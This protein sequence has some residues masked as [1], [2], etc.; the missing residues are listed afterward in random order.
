MYCR[1]FGFKCAPFPQN[2]CWLSAA[3]ARQPQNPTFKWK[4]YTSVYLRVSSNN[5]NQIT[6]PGKPLARKLKKFS[7]VT[8]TSFIKFSR[9]IIS[10]VCSRRPRAYRAAVHHVNHGVLFFFSFFFIPL[11]F[12]LHGYATERR[13]LGA[14]LF[15][16]DQIQLHA[17]RINILNYKYL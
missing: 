6:S 4:Y 17:H 7:P 3:H 5:N 15:C 9:T 14:K 10:R 12:T 2:G 1:A 16:N 8:V 11:C 13:G